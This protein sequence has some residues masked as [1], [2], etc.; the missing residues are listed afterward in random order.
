[1]EQQT[2]I[3][4]N[5]GLEAAQKPQRRHFPIYFVQDCTFTY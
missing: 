1:M 3:P 2:P 4:P 5:Q